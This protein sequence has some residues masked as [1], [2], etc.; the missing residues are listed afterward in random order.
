MLII[1]TKGQELSTKYNG[2]CVWIWTKL[3]WRKENDK[4]DKCFKWPIIQKKTVYLL[5]TEH[6]AQSNSSKVL[7]ILIST[8]PSNTHSSFWHV[9]CEP[10]WQIQEFFQGLTG[11][12]SKASACSLGMSICQGSHSHS[13]NNQPIFPSGIDLAEETLPASKER[14]CIR[15]WP[16]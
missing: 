7:R 8:S 9:N 6:R 10:N 14:L 12:A 13:Q 2:N 3:I 16:K 15:N 11:L 4:C 5:S 1:T